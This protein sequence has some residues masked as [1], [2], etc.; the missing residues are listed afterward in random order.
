MSNQQIAVKDAEYVHDYVI[1]IFFVNGEK[2]RIDFGSFLRKQHN[3]SLTKY[4]DVNKFKSYEIVHGDLIWGDYEMCFPVWDLFIGEIEKSESSTN[5]LNE[6]LTVKHILGDAV[7]VFKDR[8]YNILIYKSP[9]I[10]NYFVNARG[11]IINQEKGKL[12]IN[13]VLDFI[14]EEIYQDAHKYLNT[15][16]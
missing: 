11:Q 3:P 9:V 8:S 10:G 14:N 5:P 15:E 12:E 1:D 2:R 4:L 7:K 6:L 16:Q 13:L